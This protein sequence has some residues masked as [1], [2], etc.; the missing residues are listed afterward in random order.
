MSSRAIVYGGARK[1][2]QEEAARAERE[3]R[4]KQREKDRERSALLA[5]RKLTG[6]YRATSLIRN[7][8][9]LGPYSRPMSRA[10]IKS[11]GGGSFL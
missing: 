9:A 4:E 7:S 5:A 8:S 1:K 10:L 3:E 2:E 11:W 6:L